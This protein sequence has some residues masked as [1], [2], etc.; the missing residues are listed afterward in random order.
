MLMA[1][2]LNSLIGVIERRVA[3]CQPEPGAISNS[4]LAQRCRA[5]K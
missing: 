4:V 2:A 5:M 3:P 1:V